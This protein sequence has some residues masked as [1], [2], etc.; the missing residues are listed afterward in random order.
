MKKK[1]TAVLLVLAV[2]LGALPGMAL[3]AEKTGG[4]DPEGG[5]QAAYYALEGVKAGVPA[6]LAEPDGFTYSGTGDAVITGVNI[7]KGPYY[8]EYCHIGEG[9]YRFKLYYG[10]GK[11]DYFSIA[12]GLDFCAGETALYKEKHAAVLGGWLEIEAKGCWTITFKPVAGTTTTHVKGAGDTVTG[13]FVAKSARNIVDVCYTGERVF[14]VL[15]VQCSGKRSGTR[16]NVYSG[17]GA[18]SGQELAAL[19]PGEE[20]YI[21]VETSEGE[22]ELDFNQGDALTDLTPKKT[23]LDLVRYVYNNGIRG[24]ANG[25]S[26]R[27]TGDFFTLGDPYFTIATTIRYIPDANILILAYEERM[28][29]GVSTSVIFGYDIESRRG[30]P[31]EVKVNVTD[32][33]LLFACMAPFNIAAYAGTETTLDFQLSEEGL[34]LYPDYKDLCNKRVRYAVGFWD[35]FVQKETGVS[36]NDIGFESCDSKHDAWDMIKAVGNEAIFFGPLETDVI[37]FRVHYDEKGQMIKIVPG[38]VE[39]DKLIFP[40]A[41]TEEGDCIF[42]LSRGTKIP[43]KARTVLG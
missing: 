4:A 12:S 31:V 2:A 21:C 36:L 8:A 22:W 23:T 1:L 43:L 13:K 34:Y 38:T 33:D 11:S 10:E 19:E 32:G 3:A 18:H 27:Q 17:L 37:A 14:R 41:E 15:A 6:P 42:I 24:S 26:Y 29:G 25:M 16:V 28:E 9:V 39:G 40:D 35:K 20:Y 5:D 30:S 7:P